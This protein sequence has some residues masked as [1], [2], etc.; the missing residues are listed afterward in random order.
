MRRVALAVAVFVT[1]PAPAGSPRA[2]QQ[3]I[4]LSWVG[5][6]AEANAS[7]LVS[8]DR[9]AATPALPAAAL[10]HFPVRRAAGRHGA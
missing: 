8:L 10:S 4:A 2:S 3:A 5:G 1:A 7:S 6:C 9:F